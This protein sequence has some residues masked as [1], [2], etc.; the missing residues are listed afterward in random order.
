VADPIN[1][2]TKLDTLGVSLVH[3]G[4]NKKR[5]AIA[6]SEE[7]VMDEKAIEMLS[8]V[9]KEA[10]YDDESIVLEQL[11]KVQLNEKS[12]SAVNG[13]IRILSAFSDDPEVKKLLDVL[14]AAIGGPAQMPE[15]PALVATAKSKKME[16]D[17]M[18]P[19]YPAP[20]AKALEGLA[21]EQRT[22]FE[23]VLKAIWD[24]SQAAAEER[25]VKAE[26]RA[27]KTEERAAATEQVLKAERDERLTKEFVAKAATELANVPGKP[28]ELGLMLKSLHDANPELCKKFEGVLKSAQTALKE[29][30]LFIEKGRSGSGDVDDDPFTKIEKAAAA[31]VQ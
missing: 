17:K 2:L 25:I 22:A 26:E 15:A 4:A 13:A 3:R 21:A 28:E 24:A 23:P 19:N 27:T 30:A 11:K 5:F 1:V 8:A 20:M 14:K 9:L 12:T 29:S 10:G 16:E 6:K 31:S 18:K 7:V